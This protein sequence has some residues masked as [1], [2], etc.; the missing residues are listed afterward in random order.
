MP[1]DNFQSESD[2]SSSILATVTP[3]SEQQPFVEADALRGKATD[4]FSH[5]DT[6]MHREYHP[7]INGKHWELC[8]LYLNSRL[9][10]AVPMTK[11]ETKVTLIVLQLQKRKSQTLYEPK[12]LVN[13]QFF[14]SKY[15]TSKSKIQHFL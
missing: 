12:T 6:N 14:H 1:S 4:Q 7:H 11:T 9:S 3:S 8:I 2:Q 15:H 10:K 5:R 13:Y